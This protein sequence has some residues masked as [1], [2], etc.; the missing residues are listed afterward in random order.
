[1]TGRNTPE[2]EG[3]KIV[4]PI[5]KVC[6]YGGTLVALD[7]SG[8]AIPAKKAADLT[9]IGRAEETVDNSSGTA[10]AMTITVKRGVFKWDNDSAASNK[11]K[12]AHLMKPCYVL[13][14]CTVTSSETGS[15][16][17]GKVISVDEDGVYV[18]TL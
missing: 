8:Y 7:A 11:I 1:M 4:V 5:G 12:A 13:D 15:S 9:V 10:G 3:K 2:R 6:I 14:E 16:V 18:E 17:A